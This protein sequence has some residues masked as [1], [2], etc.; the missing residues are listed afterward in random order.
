MQIQICTFLIDPREKH[1][2]HCPS[3][4]FM[5]TLGLKNIINIVHTLQIFMVFHPLSNVRL[6][7]PIRSPR[8]YSPISSFLPSSFMITERSRPLSTMKVL[9][10]FSPCLKY[11]QINSLH[12]CK[13]L[14]DPQQNLRF[15]DMFGKD[16]K[17]TKKQ[18]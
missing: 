16:L 10:D 3:L 2:K 18:N 4:I 7:T 15:V 14:C 5:K 13:Q 1:S 8:P 17:K 12:I 11:I 6:T 9:S